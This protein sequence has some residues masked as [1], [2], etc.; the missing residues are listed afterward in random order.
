MSRTTGLLSIAAAAL[1]PLSAATAR[2]AASKTPNAHITIKPA[3]GTPRTTFTLAFTSPDRTGHT[4]SFNRRDVAE[5]GV[6][7]TAS[8][9][10]VFQL[11]QTAPAS[12]AH[13]RVKM[14]L[15]PP[16]PHDKWCA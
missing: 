12:R 14:L 6:T 11:E 16:T 7:T 9:A 13:A 4:G 2:P 3:T 8:S 10:C 5:A 1:V 15:K